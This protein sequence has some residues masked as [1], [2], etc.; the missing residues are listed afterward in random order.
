MAFDVGGNAQDLPNP[1]AGLGSAYGKTPR[2]LSWPSRTDLKR[3]GRGTKEREAEKQSD[4]E[5]SELEPNRLNKRERRRLQNLH[6]QRAFRARS[7]IHQH[8]V[9]RCAEVGTEVLQADNRAA[10]RLPIAC[11]TWKH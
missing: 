9:G 10:C 5:G 3:Y 11:L 4:M 6:A 8:E 1:K 2:R 7:K